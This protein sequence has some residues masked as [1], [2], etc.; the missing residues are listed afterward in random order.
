MSF[1]KKSYLETLK[2]TREE[3]GEYRRLLR[4]YEFNTSEMI[5]GLSSKQAIHPYLACLLKASRVLSGQKL[6]IISD[7]STPTDKPKIYACTHIGKND[8]ETA[9]EVIKEHSYLMLGDPTP[10][11]RTFDGLILE[12]NGVINAELDSKSD[13]NIAKETSI[14]LLKQGGNLLIFPEGAWNVTEN[15]IVMR[16]F[17]GTTDIATKT[18]AVIIP[19][20]LEHYN[21]TF[22]ANVGNNI[23]YSNS[24]SIDLTSLSLELRDTLATLKWEI[25]EQLPIVERTSLP[26]DYIENYYKQVAVDCGEYYSLEKIKE[27]RFKDKNL[28]DAEEVYSFMKTLKPTL[29]NAF[30]YRK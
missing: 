12:L 7:K 15:E 14:Q 24:D 21:N 22:Y 20:A 10:V 23:D 27:E 30:L 19:V 4:E 16:L 2:M 11:Y 18:G 26:D 3:Y 13:R 28:V 5:K 1:E 29:N 8:I 25:S 9:F 17:N 6:N